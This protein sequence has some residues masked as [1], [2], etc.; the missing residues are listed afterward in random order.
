LGQGAAQK[1][2]LG[3]MFMALFNSHVHPTSS[4]GAPTAPTTM[5][6]TPGMLSSVTKTA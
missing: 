4:P 5:P 1:V 3:D 2:V 6:M